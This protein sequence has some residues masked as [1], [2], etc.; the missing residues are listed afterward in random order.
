MTSY[1]NL[2]NDSPFNPNPQ[3]SEREYRREKKKKKKK[4]SKRQSLL[5]PLPFSQ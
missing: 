1:T 5:V 2:F 3:E 4:E